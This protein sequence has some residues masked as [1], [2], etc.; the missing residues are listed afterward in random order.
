[1]EGQIWKK[2]RVFNPGFS[3]AHLMILV[4]GVVK[5]T[6]TFGQILREHAEKKDIFQM[7]AWTDNLTM[8]VIGRVAL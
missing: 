7:K 3:A 6:E 5:E 1:M 4:P 2:W 8:E